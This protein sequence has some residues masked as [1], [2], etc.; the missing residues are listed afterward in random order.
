[1]N[2]STPHKQ[3][4]LSI[5]EIVM[6]ASLVAVL[7]SLAIMVVN[8]VAHTPRARNAE[9]YSAVNLLANALL[10]YRD[11][12]QGILPEQIDMV[13]REICQSGLS[14]ARC[15]GSGLLDLSFLVPDYLPTLPVDPLKGSILGTS[16][17]VSAEPGGHIRISA[18]ATE[19]GDMIMVRR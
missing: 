11:D 3:R 7:L 8:P 2:H 19:D 10:R 15:Q 18:L 9:R 1:M 12:H 17:A 4:G 6:I 14:S 5:I 13:T 16:Y